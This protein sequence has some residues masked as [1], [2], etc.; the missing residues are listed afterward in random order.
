LIYVSAAVILEYYLYSTPNANGEVLSQRNISVPIVTDFIWREERRTV[1]D[2]KSLDR[3]SK[4]IIYLSLVRLAG[5]F[6]YCSY[7]FL[8]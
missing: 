3:F 8:R 7:Y 2:G 4:V 5:L 1:W 6:T